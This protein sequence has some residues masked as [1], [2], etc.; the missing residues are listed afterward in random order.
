[1]TMG[2]VKKRK[3]RAYR[4][5]TT[6]TVLRFTPTRDFLLTMQDLQLDAGQAKVQVMTGGTP[7]GTFTDIPSKFC[8]N[9]IG[10]DVA[11]FSTVA[12]GGT[13]TGGTER[14][15]LRANAGAGQGSGR[16][17]TAGARLLQAGTYYM[18]ITVTGTTSGVYSFEFEEL[19]TVLGVPV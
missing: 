7:G 11:G 12:A 16:P 17:S 1:M 8:M 3:F 13:L 19:D 2:L 6:A 18:V 14:E 10:G 15:V 9:T 5:F 4:E